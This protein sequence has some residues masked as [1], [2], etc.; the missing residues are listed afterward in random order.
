MATATPARPRDSQ[1]PTARIER[2]DA[3][4]TRPAASGWLAS[5][6][7]A[8]GLIFLWAFADK[9][10][11]LGYSTPAERAWI[12]GGSP[13]KGFL[14]SIDAGPLASTFQSM[15]GDW[16]VDWLFMLALL[17]I[18]VTVVAG[19]A[20]RLAAAAGT[21]LMA[22]MWIAEWHPARWTSAGEATGSTNPLIDYHVIYALVLIVL[23]ATAAGHRWGFGKAWARLP[24]VGR[25]HTTLS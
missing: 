5:L 16:W 21:L 1:L 15:A 6:R 24:I 19:I 23:A 11:G 8:T 9:L 22:S 4:N 2:D 10:L 14:S 18:G 7:I 17:A 3:A 25:H 13:T 12:N 20:L